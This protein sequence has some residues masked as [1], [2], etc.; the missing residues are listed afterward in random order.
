MTA[1][2]D[3]LQSFPEGL[4][5]RDAR[6]ELLLMLP[7]NREDNIHYRIYNTSGTL[8]T[9]SDGQRT[10]LYAGVHVVGNR[11]LSGRPPAPKPI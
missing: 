2:S 8:I 6:G 11:Q 5:V 1:D 9:C 10:Q 3:G 4:T 7:A